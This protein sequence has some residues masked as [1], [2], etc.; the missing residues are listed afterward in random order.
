MKSS[1]FP[2]VLE[3]ILQGLGSGDAS[4][5]E[6]GIRDTSHIYPYDDVW[7]ELTQVCLSCVPKHS[8]IKT[9]A[10]ACKLLMGNRCAR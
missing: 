4:I 6:Y 1:S 3:D 8:S 9:C 10:I 2:E 7:E 5:L